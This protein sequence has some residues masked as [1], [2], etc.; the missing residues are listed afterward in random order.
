MGQSLGRMRGLVGSL[1]VGEAKMKVRVQSVLPALELYYPSYPALNSLPNLASRWQRRVENEH[2]QRRSD[3]SPGFF[4]RWVASVFI[5][6][7]GTRGARA[8]R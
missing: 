3:C 4:L 2:L 1:D 6:E 5:Q 8:T 7:D